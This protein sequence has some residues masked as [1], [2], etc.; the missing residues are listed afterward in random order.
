MNGPI[1]VVLTQKRQENPNKQTDNDQKERT[2]LLNLIKLY[3]QTILYLNAID[4]STIHIN[5]FV[6]QQVVRLQL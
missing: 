4:Y 5:S 1:Y 2:K 6:E 3:N